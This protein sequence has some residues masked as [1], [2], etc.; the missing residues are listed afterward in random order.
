MRLFLSDIDLLI[1]VEWVRFIDCG[2]DFVNIHVGCAGNLRVIFND[3]P[4]ALYNVMIRR[5]KI[6]GYY[7]IDGDLFCGYE[8]IN[9]GIS[10]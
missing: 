4:I 2:N 8:L 1:S 7:V 9:N 3:V 10:L 6:D 5:L